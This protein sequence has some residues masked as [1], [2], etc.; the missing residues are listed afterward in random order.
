MTFTYELDLDTVKVNQN[1]KHLGQRSFS[2]TAMC[3]S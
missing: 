2:S 1:A 3:H